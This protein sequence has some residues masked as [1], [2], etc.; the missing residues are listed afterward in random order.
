MSVCRFEKTFL[1]IRYPI[2]S[3]D[4]LNWEEL[5]QLTKKNI[6][7]DKIFSYHDKGLKIVV[8][9]VDNFLEVIVKH[10]MVQRYSNLFI[11]MIHA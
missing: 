1:E 2:L 8:N 11:K 3:R 10:D 5:G 9:L 6:R 7:D 4:K